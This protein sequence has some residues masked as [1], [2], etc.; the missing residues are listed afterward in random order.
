MK[1]TQYVKT[2]FFILWNMITF[3]CL[4]I[5]PQ[6]LN[7]VKELCLSVLKRID[8]YFYNI[9]LYLKEL[10]KKII[11]NKNNKADASSAQPINKS[12]KQVL[13]SFDINNNILNQAV[14]SSKRLSNNKL[15]DA[16]ATQNLI[17]KQHFFRLQDKCAFLYSFVSKNHCSL[18]IF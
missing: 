15:K 9:F 18:Y 14:K 17:S 4:I 13:N 11:I 10:K 3:L 12:K 16:P 7:S 2:L 5:A 1:I 6:N 8:S